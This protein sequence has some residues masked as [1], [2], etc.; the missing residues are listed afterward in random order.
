MKEEVKELLL[1]TKREGMEKLVGALDKVNFFEMPAST[2]FH[3]NYEGGLIEHSLSVY[4]LFKEMIEKFKLELKEDS[5]IICSI[6]HDVC[7]ANQYIRN[8]KSWGWN[9]SNPKG[10][11]KLSLSRIKQF[12]KLND[13]EEQIIKYHMGFY[14]IS[15]F[16]DKG[17]YTLMEMVNAYNINKLAKLFYFCDD[18]S[19]QFLEEKR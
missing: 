18:M 1:S 17:E 9:A 2:K 10:H 16:S 4:K 13:E 12:I 8:G 19:S 15:A 3:G 11:A 14:G 6:L 5:I 7:K